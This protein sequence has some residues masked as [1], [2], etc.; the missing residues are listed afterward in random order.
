MLKKYFILFVLVIL[1]VKTNAQT[2]TYHFKGRPIQL[3]ESNDKLLISLNENDATGRI[4]L[5]N[6][7]KNDPD[8]EVAFDKAASF[9]VLKRKP[10]SLIAKKEALNN[11]LKEPYITYASFIFEHEDGTWQG[12]TNEIIVEL[13]D[14]VTSDQA[15]SVAGN[16][17]YIAVRQNPSRSNVYHFYFPKDQ[18]ILQINDNLYSTGLF[19]FA[20][21]NFIR[22]VKLASSCTLSGSVTDPS[23][24]SQWALNTAGTTFPTG[25][26]INICE[27]WNLTNALTTSSTLSQVS[28]AVIDDGVDVG[29]PDLNVSTTLGYDAVTSCCGA[30]GCMSCPF[31]T[32]SPGYPLI[33]DNHGTECAGVVGALANG[34][35][36]VGVAPGVTIIPIRIGYGAEGA[37]VTNDGWIAEGIDWASGYTYYFDGGTKVNADIL[38]LSLDLG[39][40]DAGYGLTNAALDWAL[41]NGRNGL[42]CV[43]VAAVGNDAGTGSSTIHWPASKPG[44]LAIGAMS[45][46]NQRRQRAGLSTSASCDNPD[47][48]SNY[49]VGANYGT[50][51]DPA[52]GYLT[53]MAPGADIY[54]TDITSAGGGNDYVPPAS[55][56]GTPGG[57]ANTS[58]ACPHVAGVAALMLNANPCLTP[59][60]VGNIIELTADEVEPSVPYPGYTYSVIPG[61]PIGRGW[62][63]EMGYGKVDAGNAVTLSHD[64]Y[65]QNKTETG[66]VAYFSNH[67]TYAGYSVTNLLPNGDYVIEP[68]ATI[69]FYAP[70]SITLEPGFVSTLGCVFAGAISLKRPCSSGDSH[71][72]LANPNQNNENNPPI[73]SIS[74]SNTINDIHIYPNPAQEKLN[75]SFTLNE[76]SKVSFIISNIE[77]Q[78]AI[79]NINKNLNAGEQLQTISIANLMPGVYFISI[80]TNE[81]LSRFK[82]VKE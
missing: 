58:S 53:V 31:S 4:Q 20:E 82:F 62:N 24:A 65:K 15:R 80:Q 1:M 35:G 14:G 22:M 73:T 51:G 30:P 3:N 77:G 23:W 79:D 10:G 47:L 6:K 5:L 32:S 48:S 69:K 74:Q 34:V 40:T 19:E 72:R 17:H 8:F 55:S 21:P 57:F 54:T 28:V 13:K 59:T 36:V 26:D 7:V 76:N 49:G 75:I 9:I 56:F 18:D 11:Y 33:G 64:M 43:V 63:N 16:Y 68:S 2:V 42:G 70:E 66:F 41:A 29:H 78:K 25:S 61:D 52:S 50:T 27:A 60:E 44:V 81:G 39:T 12:T 71:F 67:K 38:N 45:Y 46:C 37:F